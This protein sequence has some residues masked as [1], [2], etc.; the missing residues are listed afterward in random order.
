MFVTSTP[1]ATLHTKLQ[2]VE[3]KLLDAT[4]WGTKPVEKPEIPLL[5]KFIRSFPM[6]EGCARGEACPICD[7]TNQGCT[8][9]RAVYKVSCS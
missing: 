7:N 1:G 9:T 8:A 4:S 5:V 2:D 6:N 3:D